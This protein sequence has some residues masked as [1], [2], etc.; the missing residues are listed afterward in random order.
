[1]FRNES[2]VCQLKLIL[3]CEHGGNKIP[4]EYVY[5]FQENQKVLETHRGFDLGALDTFD[6]L[7]SLSDYSKASTTSRL[8]I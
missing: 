8:L 3:T 2:I 1:M 6:Y 5:L 4:N 7:K